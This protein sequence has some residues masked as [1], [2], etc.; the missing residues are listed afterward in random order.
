MGGARSHGPSP[1]TCLSF[2]NHAVALAEVEESLHAAHHRGW[3]IA[4][5]ITAFR[6]L[7]WWRLSSNSTTPARTWRTGA[8]RSMGR[9]IVTLR[10]PLPRHQASGPWRC[11]GGHP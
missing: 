4:P 10:R 3:Y 6:R 7:A 2:L 5:L 11:C 1:R 8:I 9:A